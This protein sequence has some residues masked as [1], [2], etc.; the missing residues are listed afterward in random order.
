MLLGIRR[1]QIQPTQAVG[2]LAGHYPWLQ[3]YLGKK[4]KTT[5]NLGRDKQRDLSPWPTPEN[6][7]VYLPCCPDPV[8]TLLQVP[9]HRTINGYSP[10]AL[11][12]LSCKSPLEVIFHK[13]LSQHKLVP[14][15][16]CNRQDQ[17][18]PQ[19]TALTKTVKDL[20]S[21]PGFATGL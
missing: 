11:E 13:P 15:C 21:R 9:Q 1:R 3:D 4:M 7:T 17:T 12:S 10:R 19:G 5:R 2:S 8:L 18:A 16:H 6:P 14:H 20:V